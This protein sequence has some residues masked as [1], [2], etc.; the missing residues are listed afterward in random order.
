M[1]VLHDFPCFVKFDTGVDLFCEGV[2]LVCGG[3]F[4]FFGVVGSFWYARGE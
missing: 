3:G 2:H 4:L 1:N